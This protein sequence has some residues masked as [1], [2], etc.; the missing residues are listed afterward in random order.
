[1]YKKA[2]AFRKSNTRS[3][4]NYEELKSIINEKGGFVEAYFAGTRDDE[5]CIKEESGAT[6]RCMPLGD[7]T[8]GKCIMTGREGRKIIF[9]KA[10]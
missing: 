4:E 10:Y 8:S 1:M 3:A 2:L 6:A 7:E 9:A 5:R